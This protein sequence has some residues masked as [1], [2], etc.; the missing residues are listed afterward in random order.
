MKRS[1]LGKLPAY[2]IGGAGGLL[3]PATANA[4]HIS[5][6]ILPA[7]WAIFWFAAAAP[8]VAWG[9]RQINR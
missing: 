9:V 7:G 6:G 1:L 4:M 2:A 8:F 3:L 5:E